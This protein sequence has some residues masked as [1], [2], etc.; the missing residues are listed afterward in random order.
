VLRGCFKYFNIIRYCTAPLST[1]LENCP[2]AVRD[3]E[4]AHRLP[5][6]GELQPLLSGEAV[7]VIRG[8]PRGCHRG[9]RG[10][11][12]RVGSMLGGTVSG[13]ASDSL[14]FFFFYVIFF[15]QLHFDI[16]TP[17][18]HITSSL[19]LA[20]DDLTGL[21]RFHTIA[22]GTSANP[23][24]SV[25]PD[26]VAVSAKSDAR[27]AQFAYAVVGRDNGSCRDTPLP[28]G[29]SLVA[30]IAVQSLCPLNRRTAAP[31]VIFCPRRN[32]GLGTAPAWRL[33]IA[34]RRL[35]S[36]FPFHRIPA[37]APRQLV[38]RQ[39]ADW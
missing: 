28:E 29:S 16:D 38:D 6:R 25:N 3:R 2:A 37:G 15:A 24:T 13:E 20:P 32:S 23:P 31:E 36:I 7:A 1:Y 34:T 9:W 19:L 33:K 14:G 12:Q 30:R 17:V 11:R 4:G 39:T 26:I 8:P 22:R 21:P 18:R 27:S 35:A 10:R 5:V